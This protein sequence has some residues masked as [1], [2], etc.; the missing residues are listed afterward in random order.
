MSL[1]GVSGIEIYQLG[2]SRPFNVEFF[3][4]E[5][6][7]MQHRVYFVFCE[8]HKLT[9]LQPRCQKKDQ[10]LC[11]SLS[12]LASKLHVRLGRREG[13]REERGKEREARGG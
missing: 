5:Y 10:L 4:S 6:K 9:S 2:L 1:L 7:C 12:E 8:F 11:T 3:N 13:E